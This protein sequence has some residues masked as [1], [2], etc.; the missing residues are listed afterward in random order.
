M[1]FRRLSVPLSHAALLLLAGLLLIGGNDAA[2]LLIAVLVS[3]A[4]VLGVELWVLIREARC[5]EDEPGRLP[6]PGAVWGVLALPLLGL[7]LL[8]IWGTPHPR[9]VWGLLAVTAAYVLLS[10]RWL[11]SGASVEAGRLREWIRR[12]ALVALAACVTLIAAESAIKPF[13]PAYPYEITPAEGSP[14]AHAVSDDRLQTRLVPGFAGRFRHWDFPGVEV[15][16]NSE[17]FRDREWSAAPPGT[18]GGRVLGLGD[19]FAFG[20]GV[21]A[22]EVFLR[23]F[24]AADGLTHGGSWTF[25]AGVPGYGPPQYS[26]LL[27]SLL[28][29]V[30]PDTVV[31][32]LYTG[33]DL[34]EAALFNGW[35]ESRR[36]AGAAP[37]AGG[38]PPWRRD[39]RRHVGGALTDLKRGT[40]WTGTSALG[41]LVLPRVHRLLVSA[42]WAHPRVVY[43]DFLI[44]S[45]SKAPDPQVVAAE[46]AAIDALAE[47]RRLCAAREARLVVVL[48]PPA[49][50]VDLAMFDRFFDKQQAYPRELFSPDALHQRLVGRITAAGITI[51]DLLPVLRQ[52]HEAGDRLYHD[53][54]HW[55]AAGHQLAADELARLLNETVLEVER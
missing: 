26:R 48:A 29:R 38:V 50:L 21:Q 10:L 4:A 41:R 42:G 6:A 23:R 53:E 11:N 35:L 46:Q 12:L 19:S 28:P 5:E 39:E 14:P 37:V 40:Y 31:V 25:N 13:V 43:N 7:E 52:R 45:C 20:T 49:V 34:E 44:R 15:K 8:G 55:N 17:G 18:E 2:L 16:I 33:N 3:G 24:E 30:Q 22:E 9:G 54:G 1:S 32:L 47:I 36:A 27:H 51:L